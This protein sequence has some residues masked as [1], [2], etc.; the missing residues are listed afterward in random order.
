M[1][2]ARYIVI[3][4]PDGSGKTTIADRLAD[5]LSKDRPVQRMNFAFGMMPS[6]SQVLGRSP[7]KVAPEG[8]PNIGMVR[9]LNPVKALLLAIWYGIDHVLGHLFLCC[10]RPGVVV[11]FARSYHDFLYQRAY[12]RLPRFVPRFFLS[13]GPKPDL[14]VTP[15]R[16]PEAIHQGKPELTVEEI[17]QQYARIR[18]GL[19]S[20]AYFCL[21]EAS[22]GVEDTLS[23]ICERLR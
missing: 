4:G 12:M 10:L 15:Q 9:P 16:D 8:Q 22:R 14:V 19:A 13:L 20:Y 23:R 18:G 11:V 17:A 3:L 1:M 5:V 21:V 7:R 6:I 2:H